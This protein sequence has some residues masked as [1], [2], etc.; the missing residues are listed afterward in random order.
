MM[1]A[2]RVL[3]DQ[4]FPENAQIRCRFSARWESEGT[5]RDPVFRC[6]LHYQKDVQAIE[7]LMAFLDN[8]NKNGI[9]MPY[10]ELQV[11]QEPKAP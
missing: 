8:L 5:P 11:P 4:R 3:W 9:A 2:R 6:E 7:L 10:I 1:Q